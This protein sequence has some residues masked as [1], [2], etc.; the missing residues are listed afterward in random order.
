M[1]ITNKWVGLLE[2]IERNKEII[3]VLKKK[4]Y[5]NEMEDQGNG[6]LILWGHR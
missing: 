1:I 6:E 5:E 4:C 3:D 2:E